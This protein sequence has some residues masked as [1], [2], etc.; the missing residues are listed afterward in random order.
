MKTENV[1][2]PGRD[3]MGIISLFNLSGKTALVAGGSKGLGKVMAS[4]L[5]EA[6][7][8]IVIASRDYTNLENAARDIRKFGRDVKTIMGDVSTPEGAESVA[9]RALEEAGTVEILINNVGGRRVGDRPVSIPT[10]DLSL[11]DWQSI[12]TLNLT[13]CFICSK[14]IGREMIKRR[15]DNQ[16]RLDI[17]NNC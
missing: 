15:K 8:N 7:A 5:A 9:E 3:A 6:G 13:T 10:E 11:E 1:T 14:I 12:I 16:C 2:K 4:A 17:W